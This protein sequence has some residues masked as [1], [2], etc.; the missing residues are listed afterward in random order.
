MADAL[1]GIQSVGHQN[2]GGEMISS[3]KSYFITG[4]GPKVAS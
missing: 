1:D 4:M 3:T 2:Y